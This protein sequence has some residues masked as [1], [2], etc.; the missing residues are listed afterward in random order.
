M[1]YLNEPSI[2]G[3]YSNDSLSRLVDRMRDVYLYGLK[4]KKRFDNNLYKELHAKVKD[5][6]ED[7]KNEAFQI[8]S[9]LDT[10]IV[11]IAQDLVK[12][13]MGKKKRRLIMLVEGGFYKSY[14]DLREGRN[15]F[16]SIMSKDLGPNPY[17]LFEK[18]NT[19][20]TLDEYITEE[21][22]LEVFQENQK[23]IKGSGYRF[24]SIN[25]SRFF[26]IP[27]ADLKEYFLD[28][29]NNI[30]MQK[31]VP[32]ISYIPKNGFI[33]TE[34]VMRPDEILFMN[35][36]PH[37]ISYRLKQSY[38]EKIVAKISSPKLLEK[39]DMICDWAG[40]RMVV[41]DEDTVRGIQEIINSSSHKKPLIFGSKKKGSKIK[42]VLL[43][44][45]YKENSKTG[46]KA[47]VNH[48]MIEKFGKTYP[49]ELQIQEL[50]IYFSHEIKYDPTDP[51]FRGR[52]K[53][54]RYKLDKPLLPGEK[55][56]QEK[57]KKFL[58]TCI[59]RKSNTIID[60]PKMRVI[61]DT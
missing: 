41:T 30:E 34:G 50:G 22:T 28:S 12:Q 52:Y 39:K 10:A 35:K 7:G 16:N 1:G 54:S 60:I 59:F 21:M 44:D 27:E 25:A 32:F 18:K 4:T 36:A 40:A 51:K 57:Y 55:E 26:Y 3:N 23:K 47:M 8:K 53:K 61:N 45:Y 38:S 46:F 5:L 48:L 20:Q 19:N 42:S 29:N 43:K 15:K 9:S 24:F 33:I 11:H 14:S 56:F 6:I 37:S 2:M 17:K 49:I 58:D 31:L 13:F